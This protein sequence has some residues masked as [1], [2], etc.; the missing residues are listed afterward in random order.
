MQDCTAADDRH[1]VP[2]G[3]ED[4]TRNPL[5]CFPG[6]GGEEF[7][8]SDMA[9]RLGRIR[10]I[11]SLNMVSFYE[12]RH[13]FTVPEL[14]EFYC[15]IIRSRQRSG[16]YYLCGYSFGGFVAYAAAVKLVA[17]G[18]KVGL[19]ALFDVPSPTFKSNLST[20]DSLKFR[21]LYISDR[22][23]KYARNLFSGRL[24][25]VV[26]NAL[27][28]VSTR[29]GET[30]RRILRFYFRASNTPLP[31]VFRIN[32]SIIVKACRAYKPAPY[33][34]RVVLFRSEERG[35]EYD[36]AP[37]LGWDACV[38]G[39]LIIHVVPGDHVKLM[40]EPNVGTIA[41]KLSEYLDGRDD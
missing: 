36:I 11:Y 21:L 20:R 28:F 40:S 18:E 38:T 30:P 5:F 16:P 32:D 10:P 41:Q 2:L 1:L 34:N 39:E 4:S 6:A 26:L 25:Q 35:P 33:A 17:A 8:F 7:I 23:R 3:G 29:M 22:T 19:L 31:D 15:Q 24:D 37:S 27:A 12:T 14:A 9:S 13:N